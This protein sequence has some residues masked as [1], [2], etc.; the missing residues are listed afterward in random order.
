MTKIIN[1]ALAAFGM[2]GKIFHAPFLDVH[3][4]FQLKKVLERTKKKAHN[5][6]PYIQSIESYDEILAD[7]SIDLIVVNTP[8]TLHYPMAKKALEAG[9]HVIVE[10][11]FVLNTTHGVELMQLA[12]KQ[13][14]MLSVYQNRRWDGDFLTV[15]KIIEENQIGKIVEFESCISRFRNTLR[16]NSWKEECNTG[17]IYNL[18]THIIDQVITLFGIPDR[19]SAHLRKLR[20]NSKIDDWN[21]IQFFYQE[22]IVTLRASYLHFA[23]MPRFV[24]H[25]MQGSYIQQN[26]DPQ[27]EQLQNNVKP[28]SPNYG[29]NKENT[30]KI[31]TENKILEKETL[32]GNYLGY[33][34]DIYETITTGKPPSVTAQQAL[35]VIEIIE[36]CYKSNQKGCVVST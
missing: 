23:P 6:Y 32:K 11:P 19:I 15:K 22:R 29:T 7:S 9:K 3:K 36:L 31:F 14:K 20:K 27:E 21:F 2:S 33:Y 26:T 34:N 18:S 17:T 1:T 13:K 10:K 30:G 8:D 28:N 16:N 24:L 12:E 35:K 25:G 5:N 4:G